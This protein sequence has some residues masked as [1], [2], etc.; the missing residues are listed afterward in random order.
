VLIDHHHRHSANTGKK[1]HRTPD[2]RIFV[3]ST[4]NSEITSLPTNTTL[5]TDQRSRRNTRPTRSRHTL[6]KLRI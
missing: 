2:T 1:R 3:G 4:E 6:P 5:N